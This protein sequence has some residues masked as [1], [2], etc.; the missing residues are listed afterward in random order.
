[1][2]EKT[3]KS[4]KNKREIV[5]QK[6]YITIGSI[7]PRSY[8]LTPFLSVNALSQICRITQKHII[9]KWWLEERK[10]RLNVQELS[11]GR[12]ELLIKHRKQ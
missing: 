12:R 10:L 1:M 8:Q 9:G 5:S 2:T 11:E 3:E 7:C 4:W 6:L